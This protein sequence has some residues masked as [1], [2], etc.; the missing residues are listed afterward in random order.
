MA[1]S[2]ALPFPIPFG[3]EDVVPL[4]EGIRDCG[5]WSTTSI[6]A[7][8]H[9]RL[10]TWCKGNGRTRVCGNP[11]TKSETGKLRKRLKTWCK[12]T[13]EQGLAGVLAPSLNPQSGAP[14]N[15]DTEIWRRRLGP[16][17]SR[18]ERSRCTKCTAASSLYY[19]FFLGL[20]VQRQ[21]PT[22]AAK[23][24]P[25]RPAPPANSHAYIG[26]RG[27]CTVKVVPLPGALST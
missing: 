6:T 1:N 5:V 4:D 22:N 18:N 24:S 21:R 3:G 13:E 16:L 11:C 26:R 27:M 15:P 25:A 7:E 14:P 20:Q 19:A 2:S 9:L 17:F 10:G 12:K 23:P 8:V